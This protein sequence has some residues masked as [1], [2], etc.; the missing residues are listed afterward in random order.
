MYFGKNEDCWEF[1]FSLGFRNMLTSFG[2]IKQFKLRICNKRFCRVKSFSNK[3]RNS[4]STKDDCCDY[5][6]W[7]DILIVLLKSWDRT[8]CKFKTSTIKEFGK[9][10]R[11]NII[12]FGVQNCK[13]P[14]SLK[15]CHK[16]GQQVTW[17]TH[18][19]RV[20]LLSA[21]T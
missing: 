16:I 5:F 3:F 4:C 20:H 7:Y 12:S 13:T 19:R 15:D 11:P 1:S 14:L 6:K 10:W 18:A 17:L 8:S 2:V 9:L 21:S